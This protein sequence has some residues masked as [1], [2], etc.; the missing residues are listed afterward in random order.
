MPPP[1][2]GSG[3]DTRR[4]KCWIPSGTVMPPLFRDSARGSFSKL[5]LLH[6]YRMKQVEES[7]WILLPSLSAEFDD[8]KSYELLDLVVLMNHS[9]LGEALRR[10]TLLSLY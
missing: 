8:S 9:I 6:P 7:L 2:D 5:P 10:G 3:S 4:E 1:S